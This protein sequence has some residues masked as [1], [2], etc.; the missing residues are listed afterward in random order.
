MTVNFISLDSKERIEFSP[1]KVI[2][3]GF[4]GRNRRNVEE[5]LEELKK[6]GIRVPDKVPTF[7]EL[8]PS[9]CTTDDRITVHSQFTSGEVEPVI[10]NIDGAYYTTCGSDHTDRALERTDI[11]KSKQACPHPVCST[12]LKLDSL[13]NVWDSIEISSEVSSGKTSLRYQQGKLS[14]I[15]GLDE[16][17]REMPPGLRNNL[18]NAVIFMGTIPLLTG[19]FVYGDAYRM[20]MSVPGAGVQ[21]S[22]SYRVRVGAGI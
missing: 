10:V 9:L 18:K 20:T 2:V 14:S 5:H 12:L 11:G 22:F 1:Q 17:L 21:L 8:D 13:K 3:A 4:T 7:Y 6:E 19:K 16:L 15:L